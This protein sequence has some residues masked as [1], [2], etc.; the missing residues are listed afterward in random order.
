MEARDAELDEVAKGAPNV[1]IDD[2]EKE[3]GNTTKAENGSQAKHAGHGTMTTQVEQA[4]KARVA[5]AVKTAAAKARA[6]K[7]RS[8]KAMKAAN[9]AADEDAEGEEADE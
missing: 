1:G 7:A 9:T 8:V 2:Q 6:A 5:E 3:A 4:V